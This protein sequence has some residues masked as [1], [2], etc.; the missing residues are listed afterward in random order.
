M[1]FRW[2]ALM[3][4]VQW[5]LDPPPHQLKEKVGPPLTKLS[6]SVHVIISHQFNHPASMTSLTTVG[7]RNIIQ[8]AFHLQ[9]DRGPLSNTDWTFVSKEPPH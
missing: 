4:C 2:R 3:A 9:A 1:A 5:Y 8:I 6:V 7:L